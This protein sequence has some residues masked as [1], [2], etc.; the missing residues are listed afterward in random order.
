MALTQGFEPQPYWLVS[1]LYMRRRALGQDWEQSYPL[2][3]TVHAP[4][5]ITLCNHNHFNNLICKLGS[6]SVV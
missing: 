3:L 1:L 2:P 5:V 6:H 4:E